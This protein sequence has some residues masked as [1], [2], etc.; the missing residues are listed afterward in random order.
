MATTVKPILYGSSLETFATDAT[1]IVT[2][3]VD[4]GQTSLTPDVLN[5]AMANVPKIGDRKDFSGVPGAP[6]QTVFGGSRVRASHD[7]RVASI[8]SRTTDNASKL[9]LDVI[10]KS[11]P[12]TVIEWGGTGNQVR[13]DTYLTGT[14]DNPVFKQMTLDYTVKKG[15]YGLSYPTADQPFL[16]SPVQGTRTQFSASFRVTSTFYSDELNEDEIAKLSQKYTTALNLT[17]F[18][19]TTDRARWMCTSITAVSTDGGYSNRVSAEFVFNI[20]GW[21]TVALFTIPF[22]KQPAIITDDVAKNLMV[23]IVGFANKIPDPYLPSQGGAGRFPQ[24]TYA[25][26]KILARYLSRGQLF[27]GSMPNKSQLF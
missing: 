19:G 14:S 13:V 18:I 21:D 6:T 8:R 24:Q 17:N 2:Y 10:Y 16:K 20:Q 11:R 7:M 1:G 5:T 27:G 12:Q 9:F 26:L 25:D 3:Y 23:P 4:L 22:N 15:A